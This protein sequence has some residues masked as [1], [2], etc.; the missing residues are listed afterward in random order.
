[1]RE[2]VVGY[3]TPR[4]EY[5]LSGDHFIYEIAI[6]KIQKK[7]VELCYRDLIHSI[8]PLN[9]KKEAVYK[10]YKTYTVG[11]FINLLQVPEEIIKKYNLKQYDSDSHK[12]RRKTKI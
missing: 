2:S 7:Q 6:Y 11:K 12:R 9:I 3:I 1:M 4:G 8:K 5:V 10:K